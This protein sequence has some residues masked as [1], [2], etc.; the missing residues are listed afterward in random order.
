MVHAL[1]VQLAM[2]V[3]VSVEQLERE[4]AVEHLGFLEAEDVGLLLDDQ[5]LDQRGSRANRIDVPGCDFQ[6]FAHRS[7][8]ACLARQEKGPRSGGMERGPTERLSR[9]GLRRP[10]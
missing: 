4:D 7:R 2:D 1:A 6:P 3:A 10:G 5:P 9:K 8:L